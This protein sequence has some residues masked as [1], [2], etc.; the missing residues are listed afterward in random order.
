MPKQLFFTDSEQ[1][2]ALIAT[3]PMALLIGFALDQ[4]VT[5]QKAFSGPLALKERVGSLDA[6]K[7]VSADLDA[8]FREKPAIH[9]FPGNMAKRVH[10]LAAH[11]LDQYDGDAARVWKGVRS[12]N[13]LRANI[14]ALPGFGEMKV[15]SLA[16]VLAKRFN[17][18]AAN[19]LV[20]P[21]PTLGD[22]DSAQALLDYQAAKK[23]H[24]AQW[25]KMRAGS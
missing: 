13:Q 21:H 5:V 20:P 11:V 12:S 6:E 17:V 9:R 10:D 4:Q 14:E 18:K 15:K 7:L 2:N 3:D 1:A 16:A 24:K 23:L 22:V 8:I 19:D 25:S